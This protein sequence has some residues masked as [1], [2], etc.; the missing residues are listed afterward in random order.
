M[1]EGEAGGSQEPV[2]GHLGLPGTSL[3]LHRVLVHA[4]LETFLQPAGSTLVPMGLVDG[5]FSLQVGGGLAGVDST[6]V[7]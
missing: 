4:A 3:M 2:L 5:T 7:D 6:S 1:W